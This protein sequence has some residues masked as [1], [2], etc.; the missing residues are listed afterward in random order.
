M[1]LRGSPFTAAVAAHVRV[2]Q[3]VVPPLVAAV[4][5]V[6]PPAVRLPAEGAHP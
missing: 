4:W 1:P 6:R 3:P 2:H 5:L